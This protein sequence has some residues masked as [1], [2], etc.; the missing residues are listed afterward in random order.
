MATVLGHMELPRRC[1]QASANRISACRSHTA[2]HQGLVKHLDRSKDFGFIQCDEVHKQYGGDVFV[3]GCDLVEHCVGDPVYFCLSES[4]RGQPL[5]TEIKSCSKSA[6]NKDEGCQDNSESTNSGIIKSFDEAHGYGFISCSKTFEKY[7]RDVFVH[8]D[9]LQ[10]FQVRDK[11][12]FCVKENS[13]GRPR[14]W[15]LAAELSTLAW[16]GEPETAMKQEALANSQQRNLEASSSELPT[17]EKHPLVGKVKNINASKGCGFIECESLHK[18]F[19]RDVFFPLAL[20]PE[21]CV[22]ELVTFQH[23][24]KNGQPQACSMT[25]VDVTAPAAGAQVTKKAAKASCPDATKKL[26]RACTSSNKDS[27]SRMF[28]ALY[29]GADPNARDV[30][31][32]TALMISAFNAGGGEKKCRLLVGMGAEV[33]AIY[34]GDVTVLQWAQE[35]IGRKFAAHLEALSRGEQIDCVIS[36]HNMGGAEV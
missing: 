14:A 27:Y 24:V 20:L 34:K 7:G 11:V 15:N 4:K 21:L 16:L 13:A 25:R 6:A 29:A 3:R 32:Q 26:L 28:E 35:R 5:G 33:H 1:A 30:T 36:L 23:R 12:S 19:S 31:G 22:G 17:S 8:K 2:R 9:Q 18:Q 10:T